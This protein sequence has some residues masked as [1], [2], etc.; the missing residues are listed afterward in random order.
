MIESEK[1]KETTVNVK[2]DQG[3]LSLTDDTTSADLY[4]KQ[5]R[6]ETPL[7]Q[8]ETHLELTLHTE[9]GKVR[10]GLDA[11]QMDA[12]EG[13]IHHIQEAYNE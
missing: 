9:N 4:A 13:A 10:V 12:L 8:N 7:G 11:K 6:R 5:A 1:I 2:V 3:R